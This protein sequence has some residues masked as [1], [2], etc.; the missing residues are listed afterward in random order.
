MAECNT[1]LNAYTLYA[2]NHR[3][4]LQPDPYPLP[5]QS[6]F[7]L[8]LLAKSS[9]LFPLLFFPDAVPGKYRPITK[10]GLYVVKAYSK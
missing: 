5:L 4:S 10:S 3:Y 8:S 7:Q 1:I 9:N 2:L 6:F